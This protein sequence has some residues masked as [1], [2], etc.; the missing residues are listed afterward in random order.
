MSPWGSPKA[1]SRP[2]SPSPE[3]PDALRGGADRSYSHRGT[4]HFLGGVWANHLYVPIFII[5]LFLTL[6]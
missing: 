5:S 1:P 2:E 4:C 3:E 6:D